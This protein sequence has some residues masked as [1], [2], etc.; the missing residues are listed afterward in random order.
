MGNNFGKV[1]W[2]NFDSGK[3]MV[4]RKCIIR[5]EMVVMF[6]SCEEFFL[7]RKITSKFQKKMV[8][9]DV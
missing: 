7:D 3:K 8:E 4:M 6:F 2:K 5:G 1:L 9:M